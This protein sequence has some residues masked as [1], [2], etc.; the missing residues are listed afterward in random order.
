MPLLSFLWYIEEVNKF[1]GKDNLVAN[2]P[3]EN[4]QNDGDAM[5][6]ENVTNVDKTVPD[7]KP[8]IAVKKLIAENDIKQEIT[9]ETV[10]SESVVVQKDT[11]AL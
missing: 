11:T 6:A 4:D 8:E 10:V 9:E 7:V 2:D 3:E 1:A 5:D